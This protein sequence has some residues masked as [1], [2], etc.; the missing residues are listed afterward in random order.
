VPIQDKESG[1]RKDFKGFHKNCSDPLSESQIGEQSTQATNYQRHSYQGVKL[2]AITSGG[3]KK[4][5]IPSGS[6]KGPQRQKL[7][8]TRTI[9]SA[10]RMYPNGTC[11]PGC[12]CIITTC[13]ACSILLGK[14]LV[15]TSPHRRPRLEGLPQEIELG[16]V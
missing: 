15:G 13:R 8:K 10:Q 4:T 3:E 1:Q 16:V 7:G 11:C 2:N 9:L 14:S 12:F 5:T 6:E